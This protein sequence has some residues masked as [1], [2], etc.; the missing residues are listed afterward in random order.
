MCHLR[1]SP[2]RRLAFTLI[3]LLV[4]IAI[5]AVLIGLLL[6]AVQ[7]VREAAARIQCSN[8]LKQMGLAV[9]N[10]HDTYGYLPPTIGAMVVFTGMVAGGAVDTKPHWR[11]PKVVPASGLLR[12]QGQPL[13]GALVTFTNDTLSAFGR[14]DSQ[15]KF[16]LTTF[17]QDDGAMPGKF[18]VS[19]SMVQITNQVIDKSAAPVWRNARAPAPPQPRWL[20]PKRY[21]NPAT[22]GL[23]AEVAERRSADI[24][25]ELHG[26]P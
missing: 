7:K 19:L 12:Y 26:S 8:N 23:S 22:S 3:E 14:T 1:R 15:G 4:V 9:H 5:I 20:I 24:V 16:T 6:P 25:L 18:V 10:L 2:L 11:R 21:G 17:E 13:E